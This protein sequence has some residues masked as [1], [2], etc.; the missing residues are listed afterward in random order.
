[1]IKLKT[2]NKKQNKNSRAQAWVTQCVALPTETTL[3][4]F[5]TFPH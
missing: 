1:M 5:L 4:F 3:F 2:I